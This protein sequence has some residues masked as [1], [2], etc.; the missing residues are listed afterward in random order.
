MDAMA[1]FLSNRP[2]SGRLARV[3][4]FVAYLATLVGPRS[5]RLGHPSLFYD[6]IERIRWLQEGHGFVEYLFLR[7]NEHVAPAFQVVTRVAWDLAGHRL[8][9]VTT[10]LTVASFVPFLLCLFLIYR[11]V[12]RE[13]GSRTTALA[14][15]SAF[16]VLWVYD[17]VVYWYSASSFTWALAATLAAWL[18]TISAIESRR[19]AAWLRVAG[20]TA[21]APA[22]SAIGLLAGPV[23]AARVLVGAGRRSRRAA[24]VPLAGTAAFLAI[25]A[26][27][28]RHETSRSVASHAASLFDPEVW[29]RVARAPFEVLAPAL[30]GMYRTPTHPGVLGPLNVHELPAAAVLVLSVAVLLC[31][32]LA[33]VRRP[34]HAGLIACG[35]VLIVGGY[36]L[37]YSKPFGD[38]YVWLLSVE[39]YHLFPASGLI[40]ALSPALSGPLRRFDARWTRSLAVATVASLALLATH[41]A[42][43]GRARQYHFPDQPGVLAAIDR[44]GV[45]C[46]ARG[47]PRAQALRVLD[48]ITRLSWC[49]RGQ[50][51]LKMLGAAIAVPDRS[52]RDARA[53][54]VSNVPPEDREPLFGGADVSAHIR[55]VGP[56]DLGDVVAVGRPAGNFRVQEFGDGLIAAP[57]WV[58]YLEYAWPGDVPRAPAARLCLPGES[59]G[60]GI[61]VW[62]T[63]DDGRWSEGRSIRWRTDLRRGDWSVP[64]AR[65]PHLEP[66][67]VRRLRVIFRKP[68]IAVLEPPRL[69]R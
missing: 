65:V 8:E 9:N 63:D 66:G 10:A 14:A 29:M 16:N 35:L 41:A 6:D 31:A 26:L 22:F 2:R 11:I 44:L 62:W 52:D 25:R 19:R 57:G 37:P 28:A 27:V 49:H 69:L 64:L 53:V 24:G 30:V 60:V 1:R 23:A 39:G 33:G 15:T 13:T 54:L 51:P 38:S 42:L 43:P 56:E 46:R 3:S 45:F 59:A 47:V 68:A 55:D 36:A 50:N 58:S 21:L 67:R 12:V 48:P 17:E 5:L 61:E 40:L 7:F 18:G 20:A 32:V 34:G 4:L